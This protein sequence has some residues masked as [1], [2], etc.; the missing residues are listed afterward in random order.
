MKYETLIEFSFLPKVFWFLYKILSEIFLTKIEISDEI[1]DLKLGAFSVP[2][3]DTNQLNWKADYVMCTIVGFDASF[4]SERTFLMDFLPE[5]FKNVGFC[6]TCR[7]L[8][9][10]FILL[11][12]Q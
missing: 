2:Q 12:K 10:L 1:L 11:Y 6:K 3:I 9:G 7:L 4:E 5:F 8:Q